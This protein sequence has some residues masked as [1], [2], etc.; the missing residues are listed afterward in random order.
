MTNS[1]EA[2]IGKKVTIPG[3]FNEPV[4]VE[5]VREIMGG[6]E[7]QVRLPDGSLDEA[8]LSLSEAALFAEQ[9][10]GEP[11]AKIV[12]ARKIS[13]LVESARIRLAYAHDRQFAVS[14]SGI[15]T[16]PHQI[17]AVYLKMLPQ[18]RLRFLLAD[19]PGA[20]KTIMAGLLLKELKL[21]EAIER[22]LILCPAP[23]TIQWQ[24][25][26]LR[27]FNESFDIIFSAVD[28]QQLVNPWQKSSQVISSIDYAKQE[29]VRERVWQQRWDLII[30]DEA[31]KCSAY[32]KHY[33]GRADEVDKT[34]R[35][36]LA[37][38]LAQNCDHL[39]MLTAT[40]HHGDDDRFG[41]FIRLIDPD[42][43]P[44]PHKVGPKA[45][46][47]RKD[48]L[49]LGPDCPWSLRRLKEDLKDLQGRRLFPDRHAQTVTFKL[50]SGEYDLYKAVT[51]YINEFLPQA[52]GHKKQ[53]MA[54]A[55]TVIQRRLA[56]STRAIF[57][58]IKRRLEK[59]R[60]LLDD[61]ELLSPVQR[62]RRL[63]QIQGRLV[64]QE[65][66]EDDLDDAARDAL[67]DEFT[68]ATEL[69]QLRLEI[70]GLRELQ[71]RARQVKDQAADSKLAALNECLTKS[72]FSELKDGRGKLIIFTE[73]RD[74]LYHLK[75]HLEAWGYSTCEIHGGMN[76]HQRKE[77]QEKFR[78]ASQIC[79]ATEAAGEGINLQFCHLM[80]NYDLPWNPTRLEQRLGR[81]HRIGQ[82]RD[83]YVF[84]FVASESEE[85]QPIIEGRILQRLLS[86][87]EQIRL[88]LADR[89]FDVIGEVLSLNDINLPEMLREVAYD[90]RRL[91]EYLEQIERIDP[92]KLKAYEEA[93]GIA[94][95][96]AN[97]DFSNFQRSNVEIEERR[98]MPRY[99]EQHFLDSA[100]E[101]GLKI[102]SRA[103]G[104]VRLPHVPADLRSDRLQ[105]IRRLGKPEAS[106][107]KLT[108]QKEHLEMDQH[109]DAILLG[110][111]HPLYAAV[112]EKLGGQLA[113]YLGQTGV[114]VD[115]QAEFPHFLHFFEMT[116]RGQDSKGEAQVLYGEVVAIREEL[117]IPAGQN[118]KFTLV[119]ADC[120]ID[121]SPHPEPPAEI[122]LIDP[123]LASDF[124]KTSY[125]ME[126]R[127]QCQ[128][129]R[130]H[131]ASV[132][133]EYLEK[134]FAVRIRAAQDRVMDLHLREQMAPEMALARQRAEND[135]A[136]LEQLK[137]ERLAGLARLTIAR[138]GPVKYLA[139]A[140]VLPSAASGE[141]A[142]LALAQEEDP[143]T[144]RKIELA[145]EEIVVRYESAR[146]WEYQKVGHLKIGFDIRSLALADPQTGYRDPL[147]GVRRI[148]VKGRKRG[149]PVRLTTNEW[150]KATQLGDSYWLYV[151][152][153]PLENQEAEPICIQNPAKKLDHVKKE[154]SSLRLFEIPA[155]AIES[156]K[157]N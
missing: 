77:A 12:D 141:A 146:G 42:V 1:F 130:E 37:E 150:F 93:T 92:L 143:A 65:L 126:R 6:Y 78:T 131:F 25:E 84:N 145:A 7:L 16:L 82:E 120:L 109:L 108:F 44:E 113:P 151:V 86:K 11:E 119:P 112:D 94:L 139:S 27:W 138:H 117:S 72:E 116:I 134:S 34:K 110:P 105:A 155:A 28:Q 46:E 98:L 104:L 132:C 23:L 69:D 102:E 101:I 67:V 80:I 70:A 154:L 53:S 100:R 13:L 30:I 115:P 26:L 62:T 51:A 121:L 75:E 19:D 33:S 14:M 114:F 36:Q 35:Y 83:V 60:K 137:K 128:Q 8:I 48:I 157:L 127:E 87:L 95:A 63:A 57:E 5:A 10:G 15:R 20:G 73:H 61:L 142:W 49:K 64:D 58:S 41:H 38:R 103:D 18:P 2:L 43:F 152:W 107:R 97:V 125:Q 32:T 71:E 91:D 96:T 89:V 88:V 52:T 81:I 148:E 66:E 9:T 129:E 122:P 4:V 136:D 21:R 45:Q 111:G 156:F 85:G 17:E 31:H 76:P 79:V 144:Q 123:K 3:H 124:L 54:L 22:I 106:Y 29:D 99:V 50:N 133:R 24:D 147:Q 74:T 40:P 153:D 68:A 47:I 135:L 90:P 149:K 55:R 56:S 39:L 118:E 59:Q 140:F